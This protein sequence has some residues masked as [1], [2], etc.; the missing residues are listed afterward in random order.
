MTTPNGAETT[1][2]QMVSEL[3]RNLA[4][5]LARIKSLELGHEAL[6]AEVHGLDGRLDSIATAQ[7]NFGVA[8]DKISATV[9]A[10]KDTVDA[11][12]PIRTFGPTLA[13]IAAREEE[14]VQEVKQHLQDA[15]QARKQAAQWLGLILLTAMGSLLQSVSGIPDAIR[16]GILAVMIAG[17]AIY[18]LWAASKSAAHRLRGEGKT[19]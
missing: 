11:L 17:I 18:F 9:D 13:Q 5:A 16:I 6:K 4:D 15:R 10:I 2:W 7:A 14:R 3:V 8:Q 19:R 1:L 12:V